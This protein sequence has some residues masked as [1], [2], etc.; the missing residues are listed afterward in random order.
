VLAKR[1]HLSGLTG[2]AGLVASFCPHAKQRSRHV[3]SSPWPAARHFCVLGDRDGDVEN[4]LVKIPDGLPAT[5]LIE[6]GII[7]PTR[8]KA[9]TF[10]A[11]PRS[12]SR[13]NQLAP[14]GAGYRCGAL[15]SRPDFVQWS[16]D[17]RAGPVL[18]INIAGPNLLE[19]AGAGHITSIVGA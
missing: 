3:D 9:A 15:L 2:G 17:A 16:G 6:L 5:T 18:L 1:R 7:S 11:K 8:M 14:A 10:W 4:R 12:M 19:A 13:G